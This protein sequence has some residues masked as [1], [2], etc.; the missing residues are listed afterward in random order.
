MNKIIATML[1]GLFFSSCQKRYE[2]LSLDTFNVQTEKDTYAVG[3]TVRFLFT[4]NPDNIVFWSGENGHNYDFR[5]RTFVEGNRLLL[6]FKSFSQFGVT[7]PPSLKLLISTDFSGVY[8]EASVKSESANWMD[9][10]DRAVLS[11]GADQTSSGDIDLTD[12]SSLNKKMVIA[13]QFKTEAVSSSQNRWVIRSFDLKSSNADGQESVLATMANAG[14]KAFN[15]SGESTAWTISSTQLVSGRNYTELDD[16][17][18]LTKQFDPNSVLPDKGLAIKN[19]STAISEYG[20]VFS[21]PGNYKVVFVATNANVKGQKSIVKEI[22]LS[23][24]P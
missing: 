16:D 12:I 14:W 17:W 22:N 8:D 7:N 10:T 3:D 13:F 21:Q 9:I 5:K 4:G 2:L 20:K 19:I 23:I 11:T 18:V 6:N 15:F 24:A 1:I